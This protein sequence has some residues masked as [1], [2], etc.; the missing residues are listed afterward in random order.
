MPREEFIREWTPF[1]DL[2]DEPCPEFVRDLDALLA[3]ERACRVKL[4]LDRAKQWRDK[5]VAESDTQDAERRQAAIHW[6]AYAFEAEA[7]ADAIEKG[8]S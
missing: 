7:C 8:A 4:C 6:S 5:I 2:P 3:T 1:V